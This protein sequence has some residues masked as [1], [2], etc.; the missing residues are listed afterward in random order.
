M[1]CYLNIWNIY[2]RE[3]I[4]GYH[5]SSVE[6]RQETYNQWGILPVIGI[7]YEF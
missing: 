3:N 5:W 4:A 6:N 2:N 1:I 7:E